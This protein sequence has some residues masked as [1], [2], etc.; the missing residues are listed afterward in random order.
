MANA[1]AEKADSCKKSLKRMKVKKIV[2]TIDSQGGYSGFS[3]LKIDKNFYNLFLKKEGISDFEPDFRYDSSETP[4]NSNSNKKLLLLN[5]E[6]R[7]KREENLVQKEKDWEINIEPLKEY[8]LNMGHI[9]DIMD[10]K[11][12]DIA[13][14]Q[15]SIYHFA[16]A[17]ETK[18][19]QYDDPIRVFV[20]RLCKGK[21]WFET[22]YVSEQDR[23]LKQLVLIKKQEKKERDKIINELV[24]IEYEDWKEEMTEAEKQKI[25]NNFPKEAKTGHSVV[26]NFY[27][28]EYFAK[29]II[30]PRL[31]KE[32]VLTKKEVNNGS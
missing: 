32:G 10:F 11:L 25:E 20:G 17:L 16:Y 26:K 29:E 31:E 18:K 8:G 23:A 6:V 9:K 27:W 22:S 13:V 15:E 4:I 3:Q 19:E 2:K 5:Q 14:V 1:I 12:L 30:V 21:G 28:K 7:N 24:E